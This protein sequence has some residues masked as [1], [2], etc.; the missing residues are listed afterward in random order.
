MGPRRTP[1]SVLVL[2]VLQRQKPGLLSGLSKVTRRRLREEQNLGFYLRPGAAQSR[3]DGLTM[4][5]SEAGPARRGP[6]E[7]GMRVLGR[8]KAPRKWN[9]VEHTAR[10]AA[11]AVQVG[12]G[13]PPSGGPLGGGGPGRQGEA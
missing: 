11:R 2:P 1:G 9:A 7:A 10:L 8:E 5:P 4:T 3:A 6:G 13:A 12:P